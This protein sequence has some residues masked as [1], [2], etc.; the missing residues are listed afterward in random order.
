[1]NQ[2]LNNTGPVLQGEMYSACRYLERI[3]YSLEQIEG[4]NAKPELHALIAEIDFDLDSWLATNWLREDFFP[5]E[6]ARLS[7]PN[8]RTLLNRFLALEK[9]VM[10]MWTIVPTRTT[11]ECTVGLI[12]VVLSASYDLH[13]QCLEFE[14]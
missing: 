1:M 3:V 8:L 5:S 6:Q 11:A 10:P 13:R 9:M 7:T 2:K 12:N 4:I 14:D